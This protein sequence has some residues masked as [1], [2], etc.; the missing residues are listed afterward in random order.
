MSV[1]LLFF[2][3]RQ[4]VL[5]RQT[6][7]NQTLCVM[8]YEPKYHMDRLVDTF[9]FRVSEAWGL[10]SWKTTPLLN[11][12]TFCEPVQPYIVVSCITMLKV[13]IA[14][15]RIKVTV[16]LQ[17]FKNFRFSLYIFLTAELSAAKLGRPV[18]VQMHKPKC[19]TGLEAPCKIK[20]VTVYILHPLYLSRLHVLNHLTLCYQY[21][22]HMPTITKAV[23][24]HPNTPS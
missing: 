13:L 15:L 19:N 6:I 10:N 20:V 7:F 21:G 11:D 23:L 4:N 16:R 12:W 22:M 18:D 24:S 3:S 5:N 14:L 2:P 9:K 8:H 17:I 1:C